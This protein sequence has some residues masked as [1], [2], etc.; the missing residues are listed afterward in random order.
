MKLFKL[1]VLAIACVS[2]LGCAGKKPPCPNADNALVEFSKENSIVDGGE[3][4]SLPS[5]DPEKREI[6][7]ASNY[8]APKVGKI[9]E[10]EDDRVY[11]D[12]YKFQFDYDEKTDELSFNESWEEEIKQYCAIAVKSDFEKR[13]AWLNRG[14][15]RQYLT[16]E[17]FTDCI[18]SL[19][20]IQIP[21]F[22]SFLNYSPNY[23]QRGIDMNPNIKGEYNYC[24]N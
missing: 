15:N 21:F 19:K 18:R 9:L 8:W 6:L 2:F 10:G 22:E 20:E 3:K 14:P 16:T 17:E 1:F 13:H 12:L 23:S 7:L 11:D 5:Y 24:I 4:I